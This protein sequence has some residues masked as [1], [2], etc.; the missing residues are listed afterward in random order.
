MLEGD[1]A[2]AEE[3]RGLVRQVENRRLEPDW[4]RAAVED[5]RH[6]LA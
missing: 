3:G 6:L 4:S 1:G 2:G 5:Q